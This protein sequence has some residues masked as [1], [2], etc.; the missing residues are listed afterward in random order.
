MELLKTHV[1]TLKIINFKLQTYIFLIQVNIFKINIYVIRL[2]NT[3]RYL[4]A[5]QQI[6][7]TEHMSIY[8]FKFII[9]RSG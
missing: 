9:C 2:F 5:V 3:K 7:F 8:E 6:S 1:P 4:I